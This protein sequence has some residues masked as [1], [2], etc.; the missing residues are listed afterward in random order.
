VYFWLSYTLSPSPLPPAFFSKI[1]IMCLCAL[2]VYHVYTW[3]RKKSKGGVTS[4]ETEVADSCELP[5]G[6]QES[7]PDPLEEQTVLLTTEPSLCLA[8]LSFSF[9]T[10]QNQTTF[11]FFFLKHTLV[12][13][14]H[15]YQC[16]GPLEPELQRVV[17]CYMGARN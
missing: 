9:K 5:F 12:C 2:P 1:I 17:S 6:C 11:F 4:P 3:Y 13:C 14:L 7:N 8:L 16:E 15:V 10:K